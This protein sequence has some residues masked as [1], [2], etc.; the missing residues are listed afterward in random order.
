MGFLFL[1]GLVYLFS[2]VGT[3][4]ILN[5]IGIL[6]TSLVWLASNI[7]EFFSPFILR[8]LAF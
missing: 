4:G 1:I 5:C 3:W 6:F 2:F 7:P 8:L